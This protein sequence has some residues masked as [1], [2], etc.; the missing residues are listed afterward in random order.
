MKRVAILALLLQASPAGAARR[1]AWFGA[2]KVKHFLMTAFVQSV[3]YAA[4]RAADTDHR[5]AL[6]GATTAAGAVGVGK[7]WRDRRSTRFSGRDLL[8]DAAGAGTFYLILDKS[9][10]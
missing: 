4:L 9:V 2:D 1:D 7:E 6:L 3:S 5:A 8:W 10:R